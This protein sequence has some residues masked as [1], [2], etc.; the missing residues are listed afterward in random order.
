MW[1]EG[2]YCD[3]ESCRMDVLDVLDVLVSYRFQCCDVVAGFG[4]L[5]R[6]VVEIVGFG[7]C[8]LRVSE[9]KRFFVAECVFVLG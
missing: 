9:A 8:E 3:F 4:Y 5:I 6:V 2:R 7:S 1:D